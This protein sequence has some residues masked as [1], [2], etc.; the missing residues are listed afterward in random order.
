MSETDKPTDQGQRDFEGSSNSVRSFA[1]PK[2]DWLRVPILLAVAVLLYSLSVSRGISI[3]RSKGLLLVL[4]LI[5]VGAVVSCIL[6]L[7]T[8]RE[9]QVQDGFLIVRWRR[10][11][12]R[13]DTGSLSLW[14]TPRFLDEGMVLLRSGTRWFVVLE[15]MEGFEEFLELLPRLQEQSRGNPDGA[16]CH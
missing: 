2:G 1:Q 5:L 7:K 10:S 12:E 15:E 8:P 4:T 14:K 6:T 13:I 9:F 16:S 3:L 11:E